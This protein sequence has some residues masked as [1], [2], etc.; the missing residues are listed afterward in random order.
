MVEHRQVPERPTEHIQVRYD[1]ISEFRIMF[2]G[3]ALSAIEVM[4]VMEVMAY[5]S[6]HQEPGITT[7]KEPGALRALLIVLGSSWFVV[8][9]NVLRVLVLPAKLGDSGL[10]VITLAVSFTTFFGIFTSFGISTYLI[11]AIARDP[12]SANHHLSNALALRVAMSLGVLSLLMGVAK[13]LGYSSQTLLVILILGISMVI[14]TISNVFEAAL[15]GLGQQSW[16][17]IGVAVGQVIA[18]T[19]GITLLLGGADATLYALSIPLGML[20]QC[21]IMVAYFVLRHPIT[22]SVSRTAMRRSVRSVP[23]SN[24]TVRL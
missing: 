1:T 10:G 15:Q 7:N 23:R 8:I 17:A 18:I 5:M 21:S 4:E 11:R 16:R 20:V 6:K 13:L 19:S 9:I 24:V 2:K 22:F 3:C 12:A 14:F